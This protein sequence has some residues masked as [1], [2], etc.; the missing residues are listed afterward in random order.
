M[1]FFTYY[2]RTQKTTA[3]TSSYPPPPRPHRPAAGINVILLRVY[4]NN[5]ILTGG[6]FR[7]GISQVVAVPEA[8]LPDGRH[9][10]VRSDLV[11]GRVARVLLVPDGRGELAA[12]RVR[13][14]HILLETVRAEPVAG[15]R[16]RFRPQ[17]RPPNF[18][19]A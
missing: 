4:E 15:A 16:A 2:L 6:V 7:R 12:R 19:A 10:R 17:T 14:L 11:G 18:R 5:T 1:F 8:V 13:V 3:R 9:V